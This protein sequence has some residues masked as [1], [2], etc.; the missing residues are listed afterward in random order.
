MHRRIK[1]AIALLAFVFA[2][3]LTTARP[4]VALAA[5]DAPLI[6]LSSVVM[7]SFRQISGLCLTV[8]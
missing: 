5:A 4:K 3:G 2:L 1:T 8:G 7:S 6:M